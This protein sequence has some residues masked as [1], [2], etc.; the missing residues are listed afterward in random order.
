MW[1]IH[2]RRYA[3][4]WRLQDL[5]NELKIMYIE[6]SVISVDTLKHSELAAFWALRKL[7]RL[8]RYKVFCSAEYKN[9][10]QEN[11][12][13]YVYLKH[14]HKLNILA[15]FHV[16]TKEGT[17]TNITDETQR[18]AQHSTYTASIPSSTWRWLWRPYRHR[19]DFSVFNQ[20]SKIWQ[21]LESGINMDKSWLLYRRVTCI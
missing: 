5:S 8:E 19:S 18:K 12:F 11:Q 13:T 15:L 3:W 9:N 14:Y 20:D 1:L 7:V 2:T 16:H 21:H 4:D 6:Y 10:R 17:W